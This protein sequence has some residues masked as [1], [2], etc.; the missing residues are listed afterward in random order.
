MSDTGDDISANSGLW[1]FN[2]DMV[3][4]FDSHVSKSVPLYQEGHQLVC[5]LFFSRFIFPSAKTCDA[6]IWYSCSS[7]LVIVFK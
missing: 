1:S 3:K 6:N 7:F 5:Q 2:G 4:K